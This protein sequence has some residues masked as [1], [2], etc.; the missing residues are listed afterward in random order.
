MNDDL[1]NIKNLL[2][3]LANHHSLKEIVEEGSR[4]LGNPLM[5][6]DATMNLLAV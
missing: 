3:L 5:L 6:M 2:N 1:N 4:I